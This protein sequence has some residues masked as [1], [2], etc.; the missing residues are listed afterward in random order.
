MTTVLL[1]FSCL[2]VVGCGGVGFVVVVVV[3]VDTQHFCCGS[4]AAL[5]LW[6]SSSFAA[7]LT[8]AA[9]HLDTHLPL[10]LCLASSNDKCYHTLLFVVVRKG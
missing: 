5:L 2:V 10:V 3:V 4:T 9:L 7:A 1:V 6:F 8:T